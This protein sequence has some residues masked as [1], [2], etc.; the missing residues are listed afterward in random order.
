MVGYKNT[1]DIIFCHVESAFFI[2]VIIF[3]NFNFNEKLLEIYWFW[4]NPPT[5]FQ[6]L[7]LI[8]KKISPLRPKLAELAFLNFT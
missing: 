1:Y 8:K 7:A 3:F 6:G 5:I 2:F 4:A